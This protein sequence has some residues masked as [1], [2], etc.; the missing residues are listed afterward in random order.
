VAIESGGAP[1]MGPGWNTPF[2]A[3]NADTDPEQAASRLR[4][5]RA[6]NTT[7][8]TGGELAPQGMP[9]ALMEVFVTAARAQSVLPDVLGFEPMPRGTGTKLRIPAFVTG[10][11]TSV[12]ATEGAAVSNTTPTTGYLES[13]PALVSGFVNATQQLLDLTGPVDL[14]MFLAAELGR[15]LGKELDAQLL[16]GSGAEQQTTG[17]LKAT[18][19]TATTYTDASPTAQELITTGIGKCWAE[20]FAAL[21]RV[22]DVILWAPRRHAWVFTQKDTSTLRVVSPHVLDALAPPT[23]VPAMPTTLSSTQDPVIILNRESVK[24]Y[25][26]PPRIRAME[27]PLSGNLEVRFLAT[28]WCGLIV[29]EPKGVGIVLGSGLTTPTFA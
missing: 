8:G 5:M 3:A 7:A 19:T 14:D 29:R 1:R 6:I 12:Q 17:I 11:T 24:L 2:P 22:P 21:G 16:A 9:P 13:S 20:V 18:G 10:A 26:D 15:A 28:Q 25:L 4:E 23:Q 27:E